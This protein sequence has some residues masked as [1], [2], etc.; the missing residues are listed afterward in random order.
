MDIKNNVTLAEYSNF[1]I[2]GIAKKLIK[3]NSADNLVEVLNNL[4]KD[5]E[6][7]RIFA[8]GTNLV[9][10]DEGLAETLVQVLGENI[11]VDNN[12]LLLTADA[13][14]KL[15]ALVDKA[16]ELGWKGME[17]LSGIPGTIGG[18]V[19]GNVG[20]YGTELKDI[21]DGVEVY[22]LEDSL[23]KGTG[24]WTSCADCQFGYRTSA[25]K[26]HTGPDLKL[27]ILRVKLKL[28]A[29]LDSFELRTI[30]RDIIQTREKKYPKGLKCPGS[31][32]KNLQV[33]NLSKEQLRRI[34]K[35]KIMYGKIPAG[36]FLEEVGAKGMEVGG[37]KVADYHANLI[38]NT[39]NG[40]AREAKELAN[41]LKQ[42]V[43]DKFNIRLEEEV[44]Y[45]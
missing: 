21:V 34:P 36:F 27:I 39:G 7:Y 28:S 3:A 22:H 17:N 9:F 31:Y 6:R 42:L 29:K 26:S 40:K 33:D 14:V 13:G 45:F 35:E 18:A 20:A 2:G 37:I 25:F 38:Y 23:P 1:H 11:Q 15:S 41:Q 10:P 24:K 4:K 32:F 12:N 19:Y 16:I 30:S 43:F 44:Q 5:K 8:G